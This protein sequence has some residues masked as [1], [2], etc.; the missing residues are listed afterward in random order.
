LNPL[1]IGILP[2]S[3]PIVEAL[4]QIAL[5][6]MDENELAVPEALV[7]MSV[8]LSIEPDGT[9][10]ESGLAAGALE[11]LGPR[12]DPGQRVGVVLDALAVV[13][14]DVERVVSQL[15]TH[16]LGV[17]LGEALVAH[18]H[19]LQRGAVEVLEEA[20][21]RVH[22]ALGARAQADRVGQP[23][24]EIRLRQ[25]PRLTLTEI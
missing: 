6:A 20:L 18:R 3:S 16:H 11:G 14:V 17:A 22:R 12:P 4:L 1:R 15:S 13:E 24:L 25:L 10:L 8:Q 9:V 23:R 2:D 7:P 21:G 19:P 5:S